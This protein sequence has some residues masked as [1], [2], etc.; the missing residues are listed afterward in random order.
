MSKSTLYLKSYYNITKD[1]ITANNKNN[2]RAFYTMLVTNLESG[3]IP[4]SDSSD[5]DSDSDSDSITNRGSGK[6]FKKKKLH[7]RPH[8]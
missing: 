3:Y 5:S 4:D 2:N 1:I 6:G 7:L 8:N